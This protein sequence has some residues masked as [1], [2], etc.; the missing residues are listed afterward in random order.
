VRLVIQRASAAA[1]R[2]DGRVVGQLPAPGLVVLIGVTHADTPAI[3]TRL[4]E[5][6]WGLR[7][8]ADEKSAAD[9]SAPLLVVSQFTLYADTRKG[10]RP[11]WLAAA[12]GPVSEPLVTA[13]VSALRAL[14]ASVETGVFGADMQV[15]LVND[16]PITIVLDSADFERSRATASQIP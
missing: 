7:I 11:S 5:K 14:G 12:P 13:Y 16:G 1:V 4:A 2:I 10:R 8:L 3:A 6:T 15:E 9:L